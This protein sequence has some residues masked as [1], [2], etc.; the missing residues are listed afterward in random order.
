MPKDISHN[1]WVIRFDEPHNCKQDLGSRHIHQGSYSRMDNLNDFWINNLIIGASILIKT[2]KKPSIQSVA[3]RM[4]SLIQLTSLLQTKIHSN[5][6]ISHCSRH[7]S[8]K[9]GTL[10]IQSHLNFQNDLNEWN[11]RAFG[12]N[13]KILVD[14]VMPPIDYLRNTHASQCKYRY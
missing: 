10:K 5:W 12:K 13:I 6:A 3:C 8:F 1:L 4:Q 2:F 14:C 9:S 7:N 11:L